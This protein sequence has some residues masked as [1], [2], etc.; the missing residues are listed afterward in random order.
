MSDLYEKGPSALTKN[1]KVLILYFI[2]AITFTGYGL[3]LFSLQIVEG[4]EYRNQSHTISS[5]VKTIPANRGEIFDRNASLPLVINTDSFAVDLT[6]AEIPEGYYDTVA[7]KLAGYLGISKKDV[8]KKCP[9]AYRKSYTAMEI[10]VNVPFQVISNIAE[11]ITDLPGVSWRSKPIRNYVETGS[12]SHVIGYVGD[13]TKEEINVMYNQGYKANSI[14]GK[15][16]IEKQYDKYLQGKE[17]RESSTVDARGHILSEAPIIEPPVPGKNLVLT[18]DARIQELTEKALGNRV[19][20]AVVLKPSNGEVVAMVSYPFYDQN[21][22]NSDDAAAE[23]TKLATSSNNPLLNRAVNAVYPPAST[24]KTIMTTALLAEKAIPSEK[25]IEC[26]G[27]IVYGNRVFECHIKYPGHGYL[28]LK[29]ALAQSCDVYYWVTGRDNLGVDQIASYSKEF[30]F[31]QSLEIDLPVQSVGFVPTS[32]WKERRY[33]EKWKGG[34]TMNMSIGQGYTLVTPMHVANMIA[35]VC[36]SG[37]IYRPHLLKEIRDG[38]SNEVIEE[39][40]PRILH[41][42]NIDQA[43]WREVQRDLRYVITDGTAIYPMNNKRFKL[44]GKTGTAEVNGVAKGHWHSWMAAYGP[45]DAPVDE[46]YVVVVLVEAVNDWE[47]WAPYA[48]NIIFQGI[49]ANQTYDQAIDEL[50]FKYLNKSRTRQE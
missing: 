37:K 5:R 16:G 21:L 42:S 10:R 26:P 30:G 40:E 27:R 43:I 24:F 18:I 19:G 35:M 3:K 22:F 32:Q 9:A 48:T 12:I 36:N 13:I 34:D 17:G 25:K 14:V 47:W 50:G 38:Q 46:Q 41:E 31:G 33:H 45:Y 6:P 28:D 39:I 4:K 49:L 11:N 1:L 7:S 2:I 29:N 44:A 15:T 8:D 20:A 23:Y